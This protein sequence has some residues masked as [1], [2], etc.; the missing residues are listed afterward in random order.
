[1]AKA[2]KTKSGKWR[3]RVYNYTDENGKRI[4]E[5]ITRDTK[6]EC[7][8]AAAEFKKNG[9][10]AKPEKNTMTVG[11]TID[12]Y[13]SLSEV[14]SPTTLHAYEVMRKYAFQDIMDRPVDDLTDADMQAAINRECKR[15]SERTG[16]PLS[17][18]SVKNEWGMVA[19]ALHTICG[20]QFQIRLPKPQRKNK[21]YPDPRAVMAAIVGTDIELPC[22]LAMWLSFSMSEIRGLRLSDVKDGVISIN[23]VL[24]DVGSAPTIKDTAKVDT[25]IRSAVLP[26][27]IR[28]LIEQRQ[29]DAA[30]EDSFLVDQTRSQIYGRWQTV[31]RQ[32][33]LDLSF[34]DL[35]H[36]NASVMLALNVPE[37]YAMERGGWK[38]PNVM[39]NV[40]QHTFTAERRSID[41]RI[42]G[43]FEA[44]L[45]DQENKN[46]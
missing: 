17:A 14:L 40:Y 31:C 2:K 28:R 18:K 4:Y 27:Y 26:P 34:H 37:K 21:Q 39:K 25:R 42:D 1:M 44:L 43:Y 11:S 15:L 12:K 33:D 7:E 8:Y 45:N 41:A 36:M 46:M 23:R 30:G 32:N 29:Q 9:R 6:A 38:T 10:G 35:R 22:L 5:C 3:I 13:I 19:A 20:R 24:V 16:K